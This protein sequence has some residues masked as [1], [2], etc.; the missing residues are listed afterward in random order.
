MNFNN[1]L[2]L[3]SAT[4]AILTLTACGGSADSPQQS[5]DVP[6]DPISTP[7]PK[8]PAGNSAPEFVN[9]PSAD[10]RSGETY[11]YQAEYQDADGDPVTLRIE[12]RPGWLNWNRSIGRLSGTPDNSAAGPH[13]NIRIFA[14]DGK[15]ETMLG[16]FSITVAEADPP[17]PGGTQ[18]E[19]QPGHYMSM[20]RF[21]DHADIINALK[22]GVV[23]VQKRYPWQSLESSFDNY[24]FS[25][26]IA[27]LDLL[28]S[29]GSR[30]VVFIED[31][32][33][34][35]TLPTPPY[36]HNEHTLTTRNN[37]YVAR[38][39]HPYVVTRFS[40][41]ID[42]LATAVAG[43]PGLEGIAIQ[44]SSLS[45]TDNVLDANG[46]TPYAYRDALIDVIQ[47]ARV[48]FPEE[49]IFWYMNFLPRN[50]NLIADIANVA[51]NNDV[52]MGG[53]DV[54]PEEHSLVQLSYPYYDDFKDR[55]LLFGSMQYDSYR[56]RRVANPAPGK[57]WSMD[58][59]FEFAESDLNVDYVFWNRVV[60][61]DPSDSHNWRDALDVIEQSPA[62][63]AAL[64]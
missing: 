41:L 4:A 14:S 60:V 53:P 12:G 15:D 42:E 61:A 2:R 32:S 23:G 7:P 57:Y 49:Q 20:N 52:V 30:L 31:K 50:Q 21:D 37:G 43:H 22:P 16:P 64:Q 28:A 24:D 48:S 47:A 25:E 40:K 10:A 45:L 55:M 27:D 44:E 8:P 13:D 46:Y 36:L 38:R 3:I 35:G 18:K 19:P 1:S 6:D 29:Q 11:V 54:L 33:F 17:D 63:G 51:A 59:M 34:N 62:F 58:E 9:T 5:S 56:H 39:W 26:V